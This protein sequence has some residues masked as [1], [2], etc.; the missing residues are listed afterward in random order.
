MINCKLFL[1]IIFLSIMFYYCTSKERR[2]YKKKI[3]TN[4]MDYLC[5]E[6]FFTILL[7]ILSVTFLFS[8]IDNKIVIV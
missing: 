4:I 3:Y 5:L 8:N 7:A 2:I 1:L 6:N